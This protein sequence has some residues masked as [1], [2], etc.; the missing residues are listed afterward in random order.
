VD[1]RGG[2]LANTRVAVINGGKVVER[3]LRDF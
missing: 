2:S 3:A 1:E